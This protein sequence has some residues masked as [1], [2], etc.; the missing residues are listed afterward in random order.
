MES[1]NS[2]NFKSAATKYREV[3]PVI[4]DDFIAKT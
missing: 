3:E 2:D 4:N 1:Q